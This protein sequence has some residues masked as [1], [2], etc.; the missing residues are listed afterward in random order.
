MWIIMTSLI[1][2]FNTEEDVTGLK[3]TEHDGVHWAHG[4]RDLTKFVGSFQH[5]N[6][7]PGSINGWEFLDLLIDYQL[8]KKDSAHSDGKGR[9]VSLLNYVLR[10]QD[11]SIV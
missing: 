5:G 9:I 8:L 6:E 11:V 10:H 1:F 7:P 4:V 2:D 3:E